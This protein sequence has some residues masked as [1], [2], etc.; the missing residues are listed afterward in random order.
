MISRH[1]RQN[2][3]LPDT[4]ESETSEEEEEEEEASAQEEILPRVVAPGHIHFDHCEASCTFINH[5]LWS[6]CLVYF[7][8]VF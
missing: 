3:K 7:I 2:T 4:S 8:L 5:C 6:V 1:F